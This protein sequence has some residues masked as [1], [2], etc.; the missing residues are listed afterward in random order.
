MDNEQL[1][2]PDDIPTPQ[3]LQGLES[4]SENPQLLESTQH[5]YDVRRIFFSNLE[6]CV[7]SGDPLSGIQRLAKSNLVYIQSY[8]D[9]AKK[10]FT[11]EPDA[12]GALRVLEK[13][14]IDEDAFRTSKYNEL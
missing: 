10:L 6:A 11:S 2:Y 3:D 9:Y 7:H 14:M 8:V 4:G 5:F 1:A 12:D 13:E